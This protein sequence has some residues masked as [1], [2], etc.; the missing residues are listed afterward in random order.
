MSS[1]AFRFLPVNFLRQGYLTLTLTLYYAVLN[2]K[3]A[4]PCAARDF[5]LNEM[6]NPC[7]RRGD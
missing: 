2:A 4:I 6:C 3:S 1:L 5:K 7:H